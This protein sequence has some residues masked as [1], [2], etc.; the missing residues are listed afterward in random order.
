MT[1]RRQFILIGG[2]AGV[3]G[4]SGGLVWRSSHRP[5]DT[6]VI[7]TVEFPRSALPAF[8]ASGFETTFSGDYAALVE[9]ADQHFANGGSRVIAAVDHAGALLLAH[10]LRRQN[11]VRIGEYLLPHRTGQEFNLVIAERGGKA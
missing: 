6:L 9:L 8:G 4:L 11:G 10:T 7:R 2:A 5:F 1:T 3:A